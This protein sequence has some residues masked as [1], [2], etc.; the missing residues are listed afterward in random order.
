MR[1]P[2]CKEDHDKVID[3]R[4][5]EGGRVIR[6]R[7]KCLACKRRFTTYEKIGESFKLN[8]VKKDGSRVPYDRDKVLVGLHKACYKRPVSTEKIQEIAD[9]VSAVFVPSIIG[10]ALLTF[11]IWWAAGGDFV[12]AMIRM[13]AVLVIACPCALG[14]ATPTAIMAGTGKGAEKGILFRNS[15]VLQTASEL[16]AVVL[17]KTGTITTGKPSVAKVISLDQEMDSEDILK[18]AA[19]AELGSEH[20]AGKA[21]VNEAKSH[22][23]NL[24]EPDDFKALGGLGVQAVVDGV[25]V[26][27]G[28]PEWFSELGIKTGDVRDEIAGLQEVDIVLTAI[29]GAAGLPAVLTAA[30]KGKELAIANKEPLVIAGELLTKVAKE[31]GSKILPVD[32]EHSAIFQ[33]SS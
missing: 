16:D 22:K 12:P 25:R 11:I 30:K 6:R 31:N 24:V 15:E 10:L 26:N 4:S 3:S 2:F 17:D 21:I 18:L 32:S 1:C 23:L 8:V 13:V 9:R 19:S 27:I 29:V 5:S 20:P 28:K 7:R 14:L 33:A